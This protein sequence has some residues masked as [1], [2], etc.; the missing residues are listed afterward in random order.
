[1]AAVTNVCVNV[2]LIPAY[3]IGGAAVATIASELMLFLGTASLYRRHPEAK[4]LTFRL[5]V[6][7]LALSGLGVTLNLLKMN[8]AP[9]RTAIALISFGVIAVVGYVLERH[10]ER[11]HIWDRG[12]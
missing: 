8:P 11:S 6:V 10:M 9:L 3:G 7:L 2:C 1:M 12:W 4:R 5:A